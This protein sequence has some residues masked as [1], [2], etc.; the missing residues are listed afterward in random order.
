[1]KRLLSLVI[2]GLAIKFSAWA[3]PSLIFSPS[4]PNIG[5]Q[6]C[7]DIT[8]K[9]FTDILSMEFSL[10]WNA[11]AIEFEGVQGFGLPGFSGTNFNLSQAADG[12]LSIDWEI[13]AC[14]SG[15]SGITL[16]D[17][18]VIFRLCFR[19]VG[20]Y[21]STSSI[22]LTSDPL[23]INVQRVNAC[24]NNI[25]MLSQNGLVSI[26]VRPLTISA[27]NETANEGDL[28]CVDFNVSG[29]DDM[30]GMQFS[31]NWDP[32]ILQFEDVIVL[33][34]L[35]NL[36]RSNFG[37]P[38]DP[39]V[40]AGNLTL[41]WVSPTPGGPGIN[42]QDSTV[43]FQVC[44][45]VVG[46]CET[47]SA[48]RI[49]DSPTAFDFRNTVVDTFM[50]TVVTEPGEVKVGSCAPT[51][52]QLFA[53]C[54]PPANPNDEVC[55][56]ISTAGFTNIKEF[57][58]NL[59]WNEN[60]L[61][62]KEIRSINGSLS[63]FNQSSF[64][65]ANT[66]N[67][68][69][70][71]KWTT[72]LPSG[73]SLPGGSGQLFE[74]CFKVVGVTGGS[75]IRF[76]GSPPRVINNTNA[77]IG[78]NP[79]NC[80]IEVIKPTGVVMTM[81]DAETPLGDT[82]C[83]DVTVSNFKDIIGYQFSMAWEPNHMAFVGINNINLSGASLSNFGLFGVDNGSLTFD[84]ESASPV[85]VP[86]NTVIFQACFEMTGQPQDCQDLIVLDDPLEAEAISST[87]N[88]NNIGVVSQ[89]AELC[90]LFPEGYFLDIA[91]VSGEIG[92]VTCVPV[93]VTSF[94]NIISTE[95][96]IS[97]EPSALQFDGVQ[98]PGTLPGLSEASFDNISTGVGI[99]T[100]NW[101]TTGAPA[102]LPD[103][104]VIFDLC[105]NLVGQPDSCYELRV[106]EPDP[107]VTT[108]NGEGSVLSEIGEICIKDRLVIIDT[109]ITPVSC[110]GTNDG[111][112]L[113][114]VSGG[115]QPVGITWETT[116]PRFGPEANNLPPGPVVVTIFDNSNPALILRDTFEIPLNSDLPVAN[117]GEDRPFVCNPPILPLQGQGSAGPNFTYRWTTQDG[118]LTP[119]ITNLNT[120][121]LSPGTYVLAVTNTETGCV[122]R[123]TVKIIAQDF[124]RA[125][126]GFSKSLA[127]DTES[128]TLG[129]SETS[130]GAN[131]SYLWTPRN[132]GL[133]PQGQETLATPTVTTAGTYVLAVTNNESSCVSRDTVVIS[134]DKDFPNANAG[135]DLKLGCDPGSS[136]LLTDASVN[137]TSVSIALEW[138]KLNGEVIG[139]TDS[140][141]ISELGTY[142]LKITDLGNGCAAI[143]TVRVVPSDEAP[144]ISLETTPEITCLSDTLTL[145][146]T[147]GN[148]TNYTFE[149]TVEDGGAFVPGTETTLA[150]QVAT[151][152]TYKLTVRDTSTSCTV[153]ETAF[154][155]ENKEF[156]TAVAGETASFTCQDTSILL[157]GT[158]S[159]VGEDFSYKWMLNGEVVA[160]DTLQPAI[161]APG[162]YYLEVTNTRNGCVALDSVIITP[163]VD[164]PQVTLPIEVVKLDCQNPTKTIQATINNPD[165]NYTIAWTTSDGNIVS[166][167]NTTTI[168]VDKEGIY[169][170][171]VTNPANGCAFSG[172]AVVENDAELPTARAG[173]DN[174]LTC[175]V[176][177]VT[178]NGEGSSTGADFTYQWNALNGGT[179]P[180][181]SNAL[182][183]SVNTPGTYELV[184]TNVTTGCVNR[185]T[186]TIEE[187]LEVP[188]ISFATPNQLSCAV[189]TVTLDA[190]AS[191]STG[192]TPQW[193]GLDGSQPALTGNPL[194]VEATQGGKYELILTYDATGCEARDTIEVTTDP[195]RPEATIAQTDT[196]TCAAP[197]TLLDG[198]ASSVTGDFRTEWSPVSGGG[199]VQVSTTNPLQATATGAGTY[200]LKIIRTSDGC[201]STAT[202]I[203]AEDTN[204]PMASAVAAQSS[205]G[206][207]ESTTLDGSGSSNGGN[208]TYQWSV[209]SGTAT[210]AN[211][212]QQNIT[213]DKAG[214]FQ[215]VVTNTQNGCA[216]TAT[217]AVTFDIQFELA[218]AGAD[219]GVCDP[220][221]TLTANQPAGT[222]G[223]WTTTSGATL[224]ATNQASVNASNLQTGD[225]RFVWTL[226]ATGCENYSADTVI[227][228][229]ETAPVAVD[230]AL[231]LKVGETQG[232]VLVTGNDQTSNVT[233][234]VVSISQNPLL[235]AA[236][237]ITGGRVAYNVKPGVFGQDEFA[238][239][240]CSASCPTL[241]DSAFVQVFIEEDPNF[242]FKRVNAITPNG[243]GLNE[244][245]VFD[246]LLVNPEQYPDN[247]LIVFN[248]WGDIVY[249]ARPYQNNW[250]GTTETGQNL[251]EGTYYYI[252]RLNISEGIIIRG[253][254]TIVR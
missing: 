121:A 32:A 131:I 234:F 44:Y 158:G 118:R 6:F 133:I 215:L 196:L 231:T 111:S 154:V 98:I 130:S 226:S 119:D 36:A 109:V 47:K 184:V 73:L 66:S 242:E 223:R 168:E 236:S 205:I 132:G 152:G 125:D 143:D 26:G 56:K 63:G 14:N 55:I 45:R 105:F 120:G 211:P 126:A 187:N 31:V 77:N 128:V 219:Q 177:V 185:D 248:R 90:I 114:S 170:L 117:A 199:N 86:D 200:Q 193:N 220:S 225:N 91:E 46:D 92:S 140:L 87:S 251:P 229:F 12:K 186:V 194:I 80:A 149:W 34:N 70:G 20:G 59:E 160:T 201:E 82:T 240:I 27:S 142:L 30:V 230:D 224:S 5:E 102:T 53:D 33:E 244:Q 24:P 206:C 218:N 85:S 58:W 65:T 146:A 214:N 144:Q 192:V 246:E 57:S 123:D 253:D 180:S 3:Q 60:I 97:W 208:I 89:P 162:T 41:S 252:L 38:N 39:N 138:L 113:I 81:A 190:S 139:N 78:I 75:P 49:V 124:P 148:S 107:L 197:S 1:M 8:V 254:V 99:I 52:L 227:V 84:W 228:K 157:N 93:S 50:L 241:C 108:T 134:D 172:D 171:V 25:G 212:N 238:Y 79:T 22:S 7:V 250:D 96:S 210:I 247:E 19:A 35:V 153:F 71:V 137:D 61:E 115:R 112:I 221:A 13:G 95:F 136:V 217:V 188:T 181:P 40:G 9:D 222:T 127:C 151:P 18:S 178:L 164:A 17:G 64:N 202:V 129:G 235:G 141:T 54:G 179:A 176:D 4:S 62:F 182:Q 147:V 43:I 183:T 94:D 249:T 155:T 169:Q 21:G 245:L 51:G 189:S 207:G 67:G 10:Q 88:G 68:V 166:G 216:D 243:D 165:P 209:L 110:P 42:L 69:L 195:N 175:N 11:N 122:A 204:F 28:V 198:S 76:G 191:T 156:P 116:P 104:T 74:V 163:D 173:E 23:P 100:V 239:T 232:T 203:V 213:I 83:I 2:I 167:Q 161:T 233:Q 29:F 37:T 103:S 135:T 106:G 145:T 159:S 150:P 16:P 174:D 101:N 15:Q 48:I 72:V 237:V